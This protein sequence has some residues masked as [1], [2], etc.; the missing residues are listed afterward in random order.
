MHFASATAE[1]G[2]NGRI[3]LQQVAAVQMKLMPSSPDDLQWILRMDGH[4]DQMSIS[5]AKF[6]V[7]SPFHPL[8]PADSEEAYRKNSRFEIRHT[9]R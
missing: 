4:T 1:L 3:K 2:E 6:A 8:D 9:S 5:S 7:F